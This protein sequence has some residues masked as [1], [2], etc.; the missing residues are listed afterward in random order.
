MTIQITNPKV[1]EIIRQRL[2]EGTYTD[3]EEVILHA[4]QAPP[5]KANRSADHPK[6]LRE[7]FDEVRGLADDIDFN[8]N[9]SSGR[10][11]EL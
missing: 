11:V 4:L 3:A 1:E 2:Q 5:L 8:R 10:P 9:P 7:M 6:T